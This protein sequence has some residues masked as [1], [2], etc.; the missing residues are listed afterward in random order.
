MLQIALRRARQR[1][2]SFNYLLIAAM[3]VI[4]WASAFAG[5][6]VGLQSYAPESLALLR[7]L[8]ASSVMA[9]YATVVRLP[10]P[11][12]KDIPQ[13]VILG[14]LGFTTYHIALSIGETEVNAG[15]ASFIISTETLFIIMLAMIFLGERLTLWGWAGVLT[16]FGGITLI[17]LTGGNG[18]ALNPM[19][20]LI[21]VAAVAKAIFSVWQKPLLKRYST[22]QMVTYPMWAG[23]AAMLIFL[24]DLVRDIPSASLKS[25]LAI[26]YMGIFPGALAYVGWSYLLSRLSA[27]VVG[28]VVYMIPTT[29]VIIAWLWLGEVPS[30]M[31]I[32][33]GGL[34][35]TGIL[36]VNRAGKI[37]TRQDKLLPVQPVAE[38][39]CAATS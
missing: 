25:T 19:A 1:S 26:G 32:V 12:K 38:L 27:A 33:G 31:A 36:I 6:R 14:L 4:L 15:T 37:S 5:I 8:I 7:F 17:S 39:G 18:L 23:T 3:T 24:P 21:L 29:A 10:L 20:L 9:I 28:S 30:S 34:V 22:V 35:L 16:S 2:T 11:A 13:L